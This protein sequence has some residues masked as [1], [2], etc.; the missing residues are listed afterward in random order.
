MR[1]TVGVVVLRM[2]E[3]SFILRSSLN[4]ARV[5]ASLSTSAEPS[6]DPVLSLSP[7]KRQME[8]TSELASCDGAWSS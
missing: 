2:A 7:V 8:W 6:N 3:A 5:I 1:A 4:I